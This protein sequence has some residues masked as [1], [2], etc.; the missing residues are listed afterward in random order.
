MLQWYEAGRI[1]SPCGT[2]NARQLGAQGGTKN[3]P[4][5]TIDVQAT[6]TTQLVVKRS[7]EAGH[8]RLPVL[9]LRLN[10]LSCW[11]LDRFC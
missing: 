4:L 8:K 6:M 10:P 9:L 5:H 2:L 11:T 3:H 1:C 7:R